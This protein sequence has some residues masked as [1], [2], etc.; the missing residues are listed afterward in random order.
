VGI[1]GIDAL[2]PI[3]HP[4][5]LRASIRVLIE[6]I[7]ELTINSNQDITPLMT[8]FI[9]P[10]TQPIIVVNHCSINALHHHEKNEA[11]AH[12]APVYTSFIEF[13]VATK[14]FFT[15]VQRLAHAVER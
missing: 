5:P 11:I 13:H 8:H 9:S 3:A 2:M 12:T 6:L 14:K 1:L 7:H 10:T 15:P 4:I